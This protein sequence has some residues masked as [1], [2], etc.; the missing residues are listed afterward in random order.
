VHI[1]VL[2]APAWAA[3]ALVC[4]LPRDK[5]KRTA[6]LLVGALG[7]GAAA[8]TL[9][10]SQLEA[11]GFWRIGSSSAIVHFLWYV[12]TGHEPTAYTGIYAHLAAMDNRGFLLVAG[13]AL[14][15]AAALGAFIVGLPVTAFMARETGALKPIDVA[16]GYLV[17]TWLL[18][19]LFAPTPWHGDPSDFIHRPF[20]LL[21]ATCAIWTLCLI[22][23]VVRRDVWTPMLAFSLLAFPAIA[24]TAG[25]MAQPKF[26]WGQYDNAIHVPN[27]LTQ[28]ARFLR[29][30]AGRRDIFAVAKLIGTPNAA[31]DVAVELCALS[32][33][34]SY[35]SRPQLESL[36]EAERKRIVAGR[37]AALNGV[38]ALG[39]YEAAMK[40]LGSLG[41]QWYV[42]ADGEGPRWDPARARAAFKSGTVALYRTP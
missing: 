28:A 35:L 15:F 32:G 26:R 30:N 12:H 9:V 6:W 18:L 33:M 34:P 24:V 31:F 22:L 7:I 27:G 19:M 10:I 42:L 14:A 37:F 36:K 8:M 41:V 4:A 21:Y 17:F 23:R 11:A 29:Q 20:V 1:F 39:D 13:I 2:L 38:A 25:A 3:A 16:C 5:R 40:A